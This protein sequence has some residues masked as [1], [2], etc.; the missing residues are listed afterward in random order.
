MR[1]KCRLC[2]KI[3]THFCK[4]AGRNLYE[5][6]LG[7]A[8]FFMSIDDNFIITNENNNT[9][10]IDG[11]NDFLLAEAGL[12]L[13]DSNNDFIPDSTPDTPSFDGYG[14]GES[15]GGGASGV[16]AWRARIRAAGDPARRL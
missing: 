12:S 2:G 6:R 3:G 16:G 7:D 10:V 13:L 11:T 14:G 5:N 15:G 8:K 4:R 9:T 1:K